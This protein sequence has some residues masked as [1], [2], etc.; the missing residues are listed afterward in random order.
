MASAR[1]IYKALLVAAW[2]VMAEIFVEA[3]I[4]PISTGKACIRR[5]AFQPN[6]SQP[7]LL[8][9]LATSK[10]NHNDNGNSK[11]SGGYKFGDL[12]RAIGR[13]VTGDNNYQVGWL[14]GWLMKRLATL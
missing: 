11:S 2:L 3:W 13:K 4:P 8:V 1:P 6:A 5:T 9:V 12:T 7:R 14:V 10:N